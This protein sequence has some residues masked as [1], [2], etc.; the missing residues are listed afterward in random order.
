MLGLLVQGRTH[1]EATKTKASMQKL[2]GINL[3]LLKAHTPSPLKINGRKYIANDI[4]VTPMEN[5]GSLDEYRPR[6]RLIGNN[7]A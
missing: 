3:A 7:T 2:E 6:T 4:D 1:Y 5:T